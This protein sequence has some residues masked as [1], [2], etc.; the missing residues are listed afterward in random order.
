M[1]SSLSLPQHTLRST[2]FDWKINS[3]AI[4]R[5]P[6]KDSKCGNDPGRDQHPILD[7]DT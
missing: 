1:E 7:L 3:A 4:S 2:R 6:G 5:D